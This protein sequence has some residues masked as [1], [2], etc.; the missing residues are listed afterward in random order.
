M[1]GGQQQVGEVDSFAAKLTSILNAD[2]TQV[3]V[4]CAGSD[5]AHVQ[6]VCTARFTDTACVLWPS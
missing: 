5:G 4:D 6:R 2:L 1:R 3:G